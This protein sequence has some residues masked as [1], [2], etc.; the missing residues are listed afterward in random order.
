MDSV[1]IEMVPLDED[2]PPPLPPKASSLM[3]ELPSRMARHTTMSGIK[4]PL[5][6]GT[7]AISATSALKRR[8]G[9][10]N[11]ITSAEKGS[12]DGYFGWYL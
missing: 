9:N 12:G 8:A 1:E 10:K 6:R 11:E 7:L 5:R 2:E 3:Q 4:K